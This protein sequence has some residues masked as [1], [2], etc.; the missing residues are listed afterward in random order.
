[1]SK[2][3]CNCL[4]NLNQICDKVE[5]VGEEVKG[6]E[7]VTIALNGFSSSWQPFVPGV[8]AYEK[9]PTYEKLWKTLSRRRGDYR[10]LQVLWRKRKIFLS[11]SR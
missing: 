11:L 6:E 3:Y 7:L 9:L 1:M 10:L 4:M 2:I 5:T 8:C